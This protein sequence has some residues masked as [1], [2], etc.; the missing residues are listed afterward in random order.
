MIKSNKPYTNENGWE[1]SEL[2]SDI[3]KEEQEEVLSWISNGIHPRK[4]INR[5]CTSYGLKHVLQGDTGIYLTN[6]QF[7]DAMMI[8]GY[9]TDNPNRLN[10][11]FNISSKSHIFTRKRR[12]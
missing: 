8:S 2:L 3:P 12:Y 11:Y 5:C 4:T 6:N 7:K 10:W 1:D 9:K